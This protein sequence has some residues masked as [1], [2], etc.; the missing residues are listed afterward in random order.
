MSDREPRLPLFGKSL[1][2]RLLLLTIFFIMLSEVLIY[3]PSVAR[4][5]RE[6][7]EDRLAAGH[8]ATLALAA[9]PD[10]RIM[11]ELEIEL[12]DH[13]RAYA[14][15]R[16][17]PNMPKLMLIRDMPPAVSATYD[18]RE[19]TMLSMIYDAF[20]TLAQPKNRV[21][22]IL[23]NSPKNPNALIEVV[24]DEAPLR[25]EMLAFSERILALSIIISLFTAALVYLSLQWLLVRPM[26]ALTQNMTAFS[27]APED[28]RRIIVPSGRGDEIGVA[29]R[30]LQAMQ[31]GLRAALRQK[32]HLAALG[33]AVAR[34]NHDL[35]NILS[36][37][38]LMSDRLAHIEAPEVKRIAPVLIRSIDRAVTLC[39]ETLDF[40]SGEGPAPK[41]ALVP[42]RSVVEEVGAALPNGDGRA[43]LDNAVDAS[44]EV[45]ADRNQLFRVL[46]N[47]GTN[48]VQAG[49]AQV[50]ISAERQNGR[51][52]IEIADDGP[53]LSEAARA[54]LFQPFARSTRS[55]GTGLGLAIAKELVEA[56]GGDITLVE[57]SKEGTRFRVEL[58][59]D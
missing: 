31:H 37:A 47:L 54:R 33:A 39:T 42:L 12:L 30:Q 22:R 40:A 26:R 2:A 51:V 44:L 11:T 10:H 6:Y 27:A 7:L 17:V 15:V 24:L 55:G 36:S 52:C 9:A 43:V 53:G 45:K 49:A 20:V 29:E 3:A 38:S 34:I 56:H 25:D 46:S 35:R 4:Y 1:S 5:R 23:G 59:A 18:L 48:A 21:L 16:Y 32:A 8:L 41:L 13:A 50:R 57:T 28:E 19:D 14:V 58:P